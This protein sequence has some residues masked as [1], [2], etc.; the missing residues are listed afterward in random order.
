[1]FA[2]YFFFFAG[3]MTAGTET[4]ANTTVCLICDASMGVSTRKCCPIFEQR[5][6]TSDRTL[7][8]VI[9]GVVGTTLKEED[10]HSSVIC[11][12]CFKSCDEIDELEERLSELKQELSTN[13]QKTLKLAILYHLNAHFFTAMLIKTDFS[14]S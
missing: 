6:S 5:V 1:M 9:N 12:K 3:N 8:T 10:V 4:S 14:G 2:K 11:K 7:A 13:Y